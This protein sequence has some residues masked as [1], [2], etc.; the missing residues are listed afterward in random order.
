[1]KLRVFK[2]IP[3]ERLLLETDAPDQLLPQEL[4]SYRLL[5]TVAPHVAVNHPA[6]IKAVYAGVAA[7]RGVTI[8]SLATQ[9][10]SNFK[11]LFAEIWPRIP[12]ITR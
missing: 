3:T 7:L 12:K 10:E 5:S 1:M 6:N 9:I 8:D 2:D 11:T 4:D